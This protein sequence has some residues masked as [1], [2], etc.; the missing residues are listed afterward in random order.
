[1]L[2]PSRTRSIPAALPDRGI[3]PNNGDNKGRRDD[4]SEAEKSVSKDEAQQGTAW[5][6][7]TL[8]DEASRSLCFGWDHLGS[9]K[10]A[11]ARH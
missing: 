6:W 8:G 5:N 4:V 2:Q 11:E 1:V 7:A 9:G 3:I 10:S